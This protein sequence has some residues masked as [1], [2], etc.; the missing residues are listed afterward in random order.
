[1]STWEVFERTLID[2]LG[3]I[4]EIILPSDPRSAI[5][6]VNDRYVGHWLDFKGFT[7]WNG[8]LYYRGDP[9]VRPL[10]QLVLPETPDRPAQRVVL[11]EHSWVAVFLLDNSFRV[12]RLD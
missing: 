9:P 12:A 7:E 3:H 8:N 2:V 5:E 4:P 6:Q 1:M 10:A 11:Y